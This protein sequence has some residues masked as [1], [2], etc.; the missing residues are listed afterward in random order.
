MFEFD[1]CAPCVHVIC[2]PQSRRFYPSFFFPYHPGF[3]WRARV[4][5]S[6][7]RLSVCAQ[8]PPAAAGHRQPRGRTV[9]PGQAARVRG[10]ARAVAQ[11]GDGEGT[12]AVPAG[13][14]ET[15]EEAGGTTKQTDASSSTSLKQG[16]RIGIESP[17]L[18]TRRMQITMGS[19]TGQKNECL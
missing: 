18:S 17:L 2:L 3:P 15:A 5:T 19:K 13:V 4:L 10:W 12:G 14:W 11:G 16:G 6:Q 9:Q 8:V 1:L 7:C